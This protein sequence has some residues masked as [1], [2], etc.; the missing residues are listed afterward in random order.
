[1]A[2][3][4]G[5]WIGS[6]ANNEMWARVFREWVEVVNAI[7]KQQAAPSVAIQLCISRAISKFSYLCQLAP[8][9]KQ[10]ARWE[11][12]ALQRVLHPP[13]CALPL[14]DLLAPRTWAKVRPLSLQFQGTATLWRA[15]F[16]IIVNWRPLFLRMQQKAK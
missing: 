5:V 2:E 1:M 3:Y 8:L 14:A 16:P 11:S 9:P 10:I 13:S 6:V 15:A 4:L 7:T 12:W